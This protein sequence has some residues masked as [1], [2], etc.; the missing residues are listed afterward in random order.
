MA[1]PP[2]NAKRQERQKGMAL[3]RRHEGKNG[4]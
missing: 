1:A 2:E 4:V 3:T